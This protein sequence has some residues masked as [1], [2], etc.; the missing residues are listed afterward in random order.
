MNILLLSLIFFFGALL[1]HGRNPDPCAGVPGTD[2]F[3]N[4]WSSC[5]TYFWCN[6]GVA[7]HTVPCPPGYGFD[8]EKNLCS[9]AAASCASCPPDLDIAVSLKSEMKSQWL[10]KFI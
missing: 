3:R 2:Q 10:Q 8:Q 7:V 6:N 9:L 5:D 1:V 4:D